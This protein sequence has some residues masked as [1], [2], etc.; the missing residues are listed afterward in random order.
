MRVELRDIRRLTGKSYL[1]D[2]PG[3]AAELTFDPP[4]PGIAPAIEL[5][6]RVVPVFFRRCGLAG[7]PLVCRP[8]GRGTGLT[9]AVEVPPDRL[10]TATDVL[11]EAL[12]DVAVW[13]EGREPA[14]AD[15]LVRELT[16][17]LASEHRPALLALLEAA[18]ERGIPTL[19]D[20]EQLTIGLGCRGRSYALDALPAIAEVPWAAL[21]S[22]PVIL[23]TGT[24]G[25]TTTSLLIH[26]ILRQTGQVT[27][28]TSTV[29]VQ[30]DGVAIEH[31]D[32]SGPGGARLVLRNPRVQL[33]VLETT[34]GGLLRRGLAFTGY[35]VGVLTNIADDHYADY[36]ILDRQG[37][38]Q[39]KATVGHGVDPG[40]T[41]VVNADDGLLLDQRF[42][43]RRVLFGRPS[44]AIVDHLTAGGTAF[45]ID[46]GQLVRAQGPE[47][48]AIVAVDAIPLAFGGAAPHNVHNALAAAAACDAIGIDVV[49]IAAGLKA[50][51][52]TAAL[53]PGR[54]TVLSNG[55]VTV[56][57]DFAHNPE[58]VG[59][60]LR[61]VAT[62]RPDSPTVVSLGMPGDRTDADLH[63]VADVVTAAR[64]VGVVLRELEP[65]RRG[66]AIREVPELLAVHMRAAGQAD[67]HLVDDD[68]ASVLRALELLTAGT[69]VVLAIIDLP[70][71]IEDLV[72]R[73]FTPAS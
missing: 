41:V 25:K 42:T 19:H 35:A 16:E 65:V 56:V 59:A 11:E 44:A 29:G 27:G 13:L 5:V 36:G 72:A 61:F 62:W 10:Q 23:V 49:S 7:E 8:D 50:L 9:V 63:A 20:D 47:R 60:V 53:L 70:G 38:A 39:V 33:A 51:R 12:L 6:H 57:L 71:V 24:N 67:V 45:F 22:I 14:T 40:G 21:G 46:D 66:R 32:W 64:P 15:R 52:P 26:A 30:V 55:E 34:R 43:A 73:G 2:R 31:G 3:V 58:S 4:L 48:T 18:A 68:R 54:S 37:M 69:L 28:T 17:R 1:L